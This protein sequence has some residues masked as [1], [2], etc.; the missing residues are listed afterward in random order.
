M[1]LY[2]K[3]G[4]GCIAFDSMKWMKTGDIGDNSCF[5]IKAT[6]LNIRQSEDLEWL[7]DLKFIDGRISNSHF[8]HGLIKL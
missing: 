7:A 4:D 2:F 5:Y 6:I 1:G 8:L 3:R